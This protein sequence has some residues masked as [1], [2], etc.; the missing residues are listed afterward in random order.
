MIVL[1]KWNVYIEFIK[2]ISYFE[3]WFDG[4]KVFNWDLQKERKFTV[5]VIFSRLLN[6][7]NYMNIVLCTTE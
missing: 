3:I 7:T 4:I 6:T 1:S 2:K 5:Y